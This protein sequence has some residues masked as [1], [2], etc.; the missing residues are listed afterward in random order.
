MTKVKKIK[1]YLNRFF[2]DGLSGMA[3]GLFCTLII[4]TIIQQ[5]ANLVGGPFGDT[6]HTIGSVAASLLVQV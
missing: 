6:L 1:D 2:I 3:L 5:I 4:G